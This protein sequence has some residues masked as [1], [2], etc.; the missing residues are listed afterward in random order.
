MFPKCTKVL[1]QLLQLSK[2]GLQRYRINYIRNKTL[3][4]NQSHNAMFQNSSKLMKYVCRSQQQDISTRTVRSRSIKYGFLLMSAASVMQFLQFST[5]VLLHFRIN[6]IYIKTLSDNQTCNAVFLKCTKV[7][8]Y[9]YVQQ[10]VV[11]SE[12][13]GLSTW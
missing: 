10:Q 2:N 6:Q 8:M 4:N 11:D 13:S 9:V 5:T 12:R 3:S 1:R 7:M